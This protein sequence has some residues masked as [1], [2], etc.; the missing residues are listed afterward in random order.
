MMWQNSHF[1]KSLVILWHCFVE[2]ME[3][4]L[5]WTRWF[6]GNFVPF[7]RGAFEKVTTWSRP[8]L[9]LPPDQNGQYYQKLTLGLRGL[10][11]HI[12]RITVIFARII[13]FMLFTVVLSCMYFISK[14]FWFTKFV[15][16]VPFPAEY[17][18]CRHVRYSLTDSQTH[19]SPTHPSPTHCLHP[20]QTPDS[21]T[22]GLKNSRLT[23]SR[24]RDKF[25]KSWSKIDLSM[26]PD[27]H[28][29]GPTYW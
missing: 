1:K 5:Q 29:Q 2:N 25:H 3:V 21:R 17:L 4:I 7:V 22:H 24:T 19:P 20:P 9:D 18:I 16:L 27:V 15:G 26:I 11:E 10:E 28:Q 6:K 14:N 23:D 12:M 13:G 8:I